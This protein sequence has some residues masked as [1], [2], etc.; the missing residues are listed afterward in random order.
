MLG[1]GHFPRTLH[2]PCQKTEI[3]GPMFTLEDCSLVYFYYSPLRHTPSQGIY[4]FLS[5]WWELATLIHCFVGKVA[6][7]Y[8]ISSS[9]PQAPV[10]WS[11]P[12]EC[13]CSS[14]SPQSQRGCLL[15]QQ[16]LGEELS[17]VLCH[18]TLPLFGQC[19]LPGCSGSGKIQKSWKHEKQG[20]DLWWKSIHYCLWVGNH[21]A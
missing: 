13:L 10:E 11:V 14:P 8:T 3:L 17:H 21:M 15:L 20:E 16:I 6:C 5:L 12:N 4:R 19:S 7:A 18:L 2:H 9:F 1:C